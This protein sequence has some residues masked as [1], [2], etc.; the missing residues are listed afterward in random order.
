MSPVHI[1]LGLKEYKENVDIVFFLMG[2]LFGVFLF[3]YVF[4]LSFG[5]F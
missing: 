2:W 3:V 4:V 1:S 5:V